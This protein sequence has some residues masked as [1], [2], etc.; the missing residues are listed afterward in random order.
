MVASKALGI[1]GAGIGD[2]AGIDALAVQALLVAAAL[3]VR[4]AANGSAAELGI[5]RVAWLAVADRMV[6]L[7][8][9]LGVGS[10]VA[11]AHALGV[12]AGLGG[13][14]VGAGLAA[15]GYDA[16]SCDETGTD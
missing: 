15:H 2:Q 6:V 12:D 13:G 9:A 5:A 7:H 1:Q 11:G 4:L 10:A 8:G 16:R 3:V 14:A